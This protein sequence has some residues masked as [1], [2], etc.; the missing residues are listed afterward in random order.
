MT[1]LELRFKHKTKKVESYRK[2]IVELVLQILL[3]Y[4]NIE[5]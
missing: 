1:K 4:F 5:Y 2:V 3:V